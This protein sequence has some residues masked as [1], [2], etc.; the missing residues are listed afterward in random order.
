MNIGDNNYTSLWYD[1]STDQVLYIDQTR[2]PWELVIREMTTFEDGVSAIRDMEV[3]GAPLIGVAAAFALYVG[4]KEMNQS[5]LPGFR[6]S[7]DLSGDG[8]GYLEKEFDNLASR[9]LATRPTAVNLKKAIDDLR[10]SIIESSVT[11]HSSLVT[12][13]SELLASAIALRS[14]EIDRCR[15]IGEH[16]L[17]LI[18]K[19]SEQKKGEPVNILTHCN[20]GWLATVDYG[21]AL[22]PIYLAHDQGISV[23][24]WVDETRPRNQGSRLTAYELSQHGVP[25]TVIVDNAGGYLMRQGLVD[26]C[27]VGADRI[28]RNGDVANKIGTYLKA[29][30][31]FDNHIPFYVAAPSSTFDPDMETGEEIPIEERSGKEVRNGEEKAGLKGIRAQGHTG[32]VGVSI[33]CGEMTSPGLQS[34]E[35]PQ[36][37]PVRNPAFDIT[38][39]RLISAYLSED[40]VK[41]RVVNSSKS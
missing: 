14:A 22:A 35:I 18:Q 38:P 9:L 28:T 13:H 25:C 11:H 29:L 27:F 20:A 23:H 4:M 12:H 2:L 40:G 24:V 17:P 34:G 32:G 3:R 26:L 33:R 15:K 36:G 8:G 19:I 37:V 16:G 7:P 6:A 5:P 21:T 30:A 10:V 41:H 1:N 31:A 39:A